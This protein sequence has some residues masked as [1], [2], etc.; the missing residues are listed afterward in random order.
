ME[1]TKILLCVFAIILFVVF[2]RSCSTPSEPYLKDGGIPYVDGCEF[3]PAC[4]Y[5]TARWVSLSNGQEGVCTL[6]GLACPAFSKDH[7]R[8]RNMGLS[9]AMVGDRVMKE[10]A[11]RKL[12]GETALELGM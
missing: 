3:Q 5:D 1:P 8:A 11:L 4:L 6:H 7:N 9:P 12:S 2:I 10:L